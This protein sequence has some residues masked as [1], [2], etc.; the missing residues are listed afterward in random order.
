[1]SETRAILDLVKQLLKRK[2]IRYEAVADHLNLSEASIKKLLNGSQISIY[3]LERICQMMQMDLFDLLE[4]LK[5]QQRKVEMLSWEQE[6]RLVE[7][8]RLFLVAVS[9]VLG[10]TFEQMTATY[11]LTKAECRS[12]LKQLEELGILYLSSDDRIRMLIS[13]RFSWIPNGPIQSYFLS[14]L[15]Q[16]FFDSDFSGEDEKLLFVSGLLSHHSISLMKKKIEKL[17]LEF[18]ETDIEDATLPIDD[19]MG[20][21]MVLAIRPWQISYFREMLRESEDRPKEQGEL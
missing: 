8:Q 15:Q 16:E 4:H 14:H 11:K 20:T 7:D 13:K 17:A 3:R 18:D 5:Q 2:G 9:S 19:R 21:S 10:F 1:M 6:Q 12:E